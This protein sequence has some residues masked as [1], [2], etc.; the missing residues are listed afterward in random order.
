M[1]YKKYPS[2]GTISLKTKKATSKNRYLKV[3][4]N[5]KNFQAKL[6]NLVNREDVE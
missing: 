5:L 4:E 2:R 3:S 1:T 6:K